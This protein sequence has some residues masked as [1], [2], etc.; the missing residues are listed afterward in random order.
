[1]L[2]SSPPR[3]IDSAPAARTSRFAFASLLAARQRQ[4]GAKH[5][6]ATVSARWACYTSPISQTTCARWTAPENKLPN[7]FQV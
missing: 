1:W 3:S 2:S 6:K 4:S 5:C 7:S